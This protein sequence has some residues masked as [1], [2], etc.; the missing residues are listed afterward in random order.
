MLFEVCV[1]VIGSANRYALAPQET[2]PT[3]N[4][5][6]QVVLANDPSYSKTQPGPLTQTTPSAQRAQNESKLANIQ[7]TRAGDQGAQITPNGNAARYL[8]EG[9]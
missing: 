8:P 7:Q 2:V 9:L 6:H 4:S 5:Q 3:G 1:F